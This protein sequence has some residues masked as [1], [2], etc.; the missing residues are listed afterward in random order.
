MRVPLTTLEEQW[1][2]AGFVRIH[3][4]LLV[5]LPHVEEVRMDAGRCTVVVG[6]E[7]LVV[8]RRHTASC[9]TCSYGGPARAPRHGHDPRRHPSAPGPGDQPADHRRPPPAGGR[10]LRDRRADPDR[11]IYMASLLRA[12][13]RLAGLVILTVGVLVAG[14]PVFF[15]LFPG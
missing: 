7:E 1:Q 14:L 10:D 12:Q 15:W 8:S 13:L 3:R 2:D 6:G 9:A 4:S 5:A 11:G